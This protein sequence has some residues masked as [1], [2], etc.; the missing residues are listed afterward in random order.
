MQME[1]LARPAQHHYIG[2]SSLEA[3]NTGLFFNY[4]SGLE[5]TG[6]G[7]TTAETETCVGVNGFEFLA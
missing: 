5:M 3:V 4:C 7:S 2:S 1:G 6:F